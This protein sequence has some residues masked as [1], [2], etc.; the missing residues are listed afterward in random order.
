MD[1]NEP[2][3]DQGPEKTSPSIEDVKGDTKIIMSAVRRKA[4]Q[5]SLRVEVGPERKHSTVRIPVM[6]EIENSLHLDAQPLTEAEWG[7]DS[8]IP[9]GQ[10]GG[11]SQRRLHGAKLDVMNRSLGKVEEYLDAVLGRNA[12]VGVSIPGAHGVSVTP[13]HKT[14]ISLQAIQPEITVT[15][16]NIMDAAVLGDNKIMTV[17]ALKQD[18]EPSGVKSGMEFE[19]DHAGLVSASKRNVE[20]EVPELEPGGIGAA[21]KRRKSETE[22]YVGDERRSNDQISNCTTSTNEGFADNRGGGGST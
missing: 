17:T 12:A 3:P 1:E 11:S 5:D 13:N 8:V 14:S 21:N 6:S 4:A 22:K 19:V 16:Q 9:G 20:P 7:R 15:A 2:D 18:L 10:A